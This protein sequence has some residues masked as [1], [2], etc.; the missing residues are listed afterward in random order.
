MVDEVFVG[1]TDEQARFAALLRE[2]MARA[3]SSSMRWRGRRHPRQDAVRSSTSRVVLVHGLGGCGKSRL[4]RQFQAMAE[5]AIQ[6][7]PFPAGSVRAVWLDW[8]DEQQDDPGSYVGQDGPSL[9]T[10]LNAVQRAF[11]SAF[12]E[13]SRAVAQV[14]QAFG[15]YRRGAALILEYSRVPNILAQS[16]QPGSPF[17]DRK[18]VV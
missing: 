16:R 15:D 4:L 17:T 18:S 11:I 2:L 13:D 10:V 1:R 9:V 3:G 8:E 5:G 12:G 14:G 6:G 7:S